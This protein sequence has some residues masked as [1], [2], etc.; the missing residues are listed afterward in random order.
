MSLNKKIANCDY[1]TKVICLPNGNYYMIMNL[2]HIF[3][4]IGTLTYP[5]VVRK[6][7]KY[8]LYYLIFLY[9]V[10][11]H[12]ILLKNECLINYIEKIKIDP[13]YK[14]GTNIEGPGI[15][16]ILS[17]FNISLSNKE[18]NGIYTE[19]RHNFIVP[20]LSLIIFSYMAIRYFNKITT[21]IIYIFIY[22][23]LVYILVFKI[24]RGK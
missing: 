23:L 6:K 22:T 10:I 2:F 17:N 3:L 13:E 19:E 9:L 15:N 21:S 12:W 18:E 8:D 16:Y 11:V 7:N 4:I 5:I 20:I 1:Y 24:C 14:L